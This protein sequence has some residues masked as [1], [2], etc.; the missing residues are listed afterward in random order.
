MTAPHNGS[1]PTPSRRKPGLTVLLVEDEDGL[2]T[3]I[4]R[5]LQDEGYGVI[6]APNGAR[7]LQLLAEGADRQVGLV[8]TDLRMPIMDGRQLAA[9]LARLQPSLPIV[10]MSGYTAQLMDMRLVSP[11]L[12]FLAKPFRNDELLATVRDQL[13]RPA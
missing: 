10:F 7:A 3:V 2:R 9:A 1:A 6:E 13:G 8:L 12:T 5:L 4:R 11:E